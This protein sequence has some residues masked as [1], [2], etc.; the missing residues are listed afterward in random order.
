MLEAENT[1]EI[2][3]V[4]IDKHSSQS[5]I[6]MAF[7]DH[8]KRILH[9]N[10]ALC[11]LLG[12]EEQTIVGSE[13]YGFLVS[14][15][16]ELDAAIDGGEGSFE[17]IHII[18]PD[19]EKKWVLVSESQTQSGWIIQII[20][21]DNLMKRYNSLTYKEST[22]RNAIVAAEHGVWDYNALTDE[23]FFSKAWKS[24]R[25]LPE[26]KPFHDTHAAWES[27]I[28]PDDLDYVREQAGQHDKGKLPSFSFEYRERK[29]DGTWVWIMSRGRV[30]DWD[31]NGVPTRITGTDIDITGM[32][33]DM[34][35]TLKERTE[36]EQAITRQNAHFDMAISNISQGLCLFDEDRKLIVSNDLY[37]TIFNLSPDLIKP[38]MDISEI[39]QLRIE[40]G[41]FVDEEIGDIQFKTEKWIDGFS[42]KTEV[43]QLTD[44][45]F[46]EIL[47]RP[48][49]NGGWLST[50][51][52]VTDRIVSQ[53]EII[54]H[55]E[56]MDAA[57]ETMT[58]GIAMYDANKNLIIGNDQYAEIY[59][60]SPDKITFGINLQQVLEMRVE[61]GVYAGSSPEEY[62]QERYKSVL[63]CDGDVKIHHLN[64][65][66]YIQVREMAMSNGR[67]L[68]THEDVTDSHLS[69][70]K[71]QY[72]ADFDSLTGLPNR[73][74]VHDILHLAIDQA[75]KSGTKLALLYIDLDGFREINETFGHPVGDQVLKEVASRLSNFLSDKITAGRLSSDEFVVIVTEFNELAHLRQIGDQIC[76]SLA[77]PI[78]IGQRVIDISASIGISV[79]PPANGLVET[80]V[81][82]SDL[83]LYQA[84]VD[85]GNSYR[86]FEEKMYERAQLRQRLA[87]DLR[88]AVKNNELKLHYQPQID[89]RT[90]EING[91]EA[92]IRWQHPQFGLV[93]PIQFIAIAEETG[94]VSAIGEWVLR[95]ACEY[96]TLWP[97]KEKISVNLSPVQFKRQDVVA[98]VDRALRDTGLAP[99]RLELEITESVLI[100]SADSVTL[101][102]ETL[103]EMGVSIALDDFGTGFSSL[104]YLTTFPFNKIKI[105]KSF[106]DDIG[107]NSEVTAIISMIISLG[108][109][110]NAVITAEG[111][112]DSRQ[113]ELLRAA[114]CDQGQGYM[115]GKPLPHILETNHASAQKRA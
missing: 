64:D 20:Q 41:N 53:N 98:M 89:L 17:P 79:G 71:I 109:S 66:R 19:G 5:P 11:S 21:I 39:L 56:R 67:W 97:N 13:L 48:M 43:F 103:A 46:V 42:D 16:M 61:N 87:T 10:P 37:A 49:K 112:E 29:T 30:V 24:M 58:Q 35:A 105:D 55:N 65:G 7:C 68:V 108:R 77:A 9:G 4:F 51:E 52:D 99:T 28:H 34:S 69:E 76:S 115:Y 23:R 18:R 74:R 93:S 40:K 85:G 22:W 94:Q 14:P 86:F 59:G 45:R 96:A 1:S 81:Q 84:K 106:I 60:V 104:S 95:T 92:L 113:H 38:G 72:L 101:V 2:P 27:R 62:V 12:V 15:D 107:K 82:Y 50:Q 26:D 100:Q 83:A 70:K 31:E 111:I 63:Q 57:L 36:S 6:A 90:G 88:I 110:L 33:E 3:T 47:Y 73:T 44:G 114:G 91:Y 32:K 25:G 75:L 54:E 8:E 80:L 78:F 102:L